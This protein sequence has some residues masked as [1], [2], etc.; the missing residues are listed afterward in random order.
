VTWRVAVFPLHL[1]VVDEEPE[2]QLERAAEG[3]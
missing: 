3:R 2:L 1:D